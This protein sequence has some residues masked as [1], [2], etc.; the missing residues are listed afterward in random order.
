MKYSH[1]KFSDEIMHVAMALEHS[2]FLK[3]LRKY[4]VPVNSKISFPV[5]FEGVALL[6]THTEKHGLFWDILFKIEND[7][8]DQEL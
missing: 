7:V 4:S 5:F 3:S 2:I 1:R 6:A 8:N